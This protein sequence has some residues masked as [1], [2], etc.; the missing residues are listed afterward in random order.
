[1]YVSIYLSIY[2]SMYL[3]IYL[4]VYLFISLS[5]YLLIYLFICLSTYL[6]IYL[7]IYLSSYLIYLYIST[8]VFLPICLVCRLFNPR[9]CLDDLKKTTARRVNVA[10][11]NRTGNLQNT[12]LMS[13]KPSNSAVR[14]PFTFFDVSLSSFHWYPLP[15]PIFLG[16]EGHVWENLKGKVV[17]VLN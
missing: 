9:F 6:F 17:P 8:Y 12:S 13:F 16:H 10:A 15:L 14:Y 1:M 7:F 5:I 3:P 2:L 4:S 11:R